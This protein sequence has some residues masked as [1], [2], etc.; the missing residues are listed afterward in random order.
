MA[1]WFQIWMFLIATVNGEPVFLPEFTLHTNALKT[2]VVGDFRKR[3]G[4]EFETGNWKLETGNWMRS[5]DVTTPAEALKKRTLETLIRIK[6]VQ[7]C[8]KKA[9]LVSDISYQGF[10]V[11]LKAENARRIKVKESGGI[12]YG[13]VQYS[14]EVYYN[15]L[16]SN[17]EIRLK[18]YLGMIRE[19]DRYE[20]YIKELCQAAKCELNREVYDSVGF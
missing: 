10:L 6:T 19:N 4:G 16:Y 5:C 13:P 8:A 15:Y 9:G 12:I 1:G 3:G 11:A 2:L 14:E 7:V 18:E 20:Q 17:L